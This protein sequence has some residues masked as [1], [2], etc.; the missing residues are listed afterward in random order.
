M[1]A[2][3]KDTIP[4]IVSYSDGITFTGGEGAS[5]FDTAHYVTYQ[6]KEDIDIYFHHPAHQ[7]FI[8]D[9]KAH[10]KDVLV[11]DSQIAVG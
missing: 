7:E 8:Q 4:Q 3:L 5:K 2:V 10:W 6:T 1:F 11:I 9:N